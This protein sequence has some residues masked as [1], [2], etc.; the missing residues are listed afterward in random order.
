MM[1]LSLVLTIMPL[2]ATA[3]WGATSAATGNLVSFGMLLCIIFSPIAGGYVVI[4]WWLRG[5]RVVVAWWLRDGVRDDYVP[6]T[7]RVHHHHRITTARTSSPVGAHIA[8]ALADR[9][10]R[11]PLAVGGSLVSALGVACMPLARDKLS[12]YLL[13]S[14]WATGEAFLV[15]AYSALA[16]D[17]TPEEQR[18]VR[19]RPGERGRVHARAARVGERGGVGGDIAR[20]VAGCSQ[21]ADRDCCYAGARNSLDN[22][23]GDIALLVFVALVGIVGNTSLNM[24]FWSA[25]GLMLLA[26]LVVVRLLKETPPSAATM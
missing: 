20:V 9:V 24:A 1:G 7:P 23:V 3:V 8:G 11:V 12:Y 16:L 17:V 25:S 26:N 6:V 22:Q 2:H 21:S 15:T 19:G 10:G 13:R 5:G 18:G 14:V 4:T